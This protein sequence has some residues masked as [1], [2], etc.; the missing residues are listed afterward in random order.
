MSLQNQ[1]VQKEKLS[2]SFWFNSLYP[3]L[4]HFSP[5]IFPGFVK[6]LVNQLKRLCLG[7]SRLSQAAIGLSKTDKLIANPS[8][9]EGGP[10][11]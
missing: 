4:S 1:G 7:T 10:R 5:G 8:F 3:S 9:D 6:T 2:V 11:E